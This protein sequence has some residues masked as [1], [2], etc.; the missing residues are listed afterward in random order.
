MT[1]RKTGINQQ[2]VLDDKAHQMFMD[3]ANE[4]TIS[5]LEASSL[6]AQHRGAK[7]I[8]VDDINMILSK[9][10][11]NIFVLDRVLTLLVLQAKSL[12]F[13]CLVT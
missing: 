1:D 7:T 12:G 13:S 6:L 8:D 4:L 3:Y 10:N 11:T 9:C 2:I 5:L